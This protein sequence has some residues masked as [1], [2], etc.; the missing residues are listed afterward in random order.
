MSDLRTTALF[1]ITTRDPHPNALAGLMVILDV[2]NPPAVSG[3]GT[4]TPGTIVKGNVLEMDPST[5]KAILG[6]SIGHT[7]TTPKLYVFA[8]DGD[9]D[10]DGAFL[11]KVTCVE[12]GMQMKTDQYELGA[13]S[14]DP[15]VALTVGTVGSGTAG[16][17][18]ILTG[19]GEPLLGFVGPGG[20]LPDGSLDVIVPQG[21][22][23]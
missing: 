19:A 11:H 20:V 3:S 8:V 9:T 12:G 6:D 5:G 10:L 14:Y 1:D 4:P 22:C 15:G 16:Q 21:R 18:T 23:R 7:A 2:L 17:L 13:G